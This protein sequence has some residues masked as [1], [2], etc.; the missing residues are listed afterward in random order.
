MISKSTLNNAKSFLCWEVFSRLTVQLIETKD[1][2]S[3]FFPPSQQPTIIVL[4]PKES[5]DFT[6]PLFHLFH[7]AGHL[8]QYHEM[9]HNRKSETFWKYVDSPTGNEKIKFETQGW[10]KGR[11]LLQKFLKKENLDTKIS[12]IEYY[13]NS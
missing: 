4:Y 12:K 3:Y 9:S 13:I 5:T 11:N 1:S 8:I 2:I 10:K 6:I 7:E